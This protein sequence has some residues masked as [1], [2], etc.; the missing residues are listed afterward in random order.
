MLMAVS[1]WDPEGQTDFSTAVGTGPFTVKEFT[2]GVRSIGVRNENYW[3]DGPYLD[4]IE[5]FGIGDPV[6]RVSAL[7]AGD[8]QMMTGIDPEAVARLE[9]TPGVSAVN[10]P[11]GQFADFAMMIDREPMNNPDLRLAIKNLFDR[12]AIVNRLYKG[13]G[14]V[15]N[16]QPIPPMDPYY[17]DDLEPR[18]LDIDK[19]KYHLKKADMV[20]ATIELHTSTTASSGAVEQA[21]MLQQQAAKAGLTIDVTRDPADGY[22]S[23]IWGQKSFYMSGWNMRP[24]CDIMLTLAFKSDAGY[25]EAKW[26]SE[27]FDEL[28]DLGRAELDTARRKEYYCEAQRLISDTGG[29]AIPC[30]FGYLDAM[31]DNIKGFQPVPLGPLAAGQWPKHVWIDS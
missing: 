27:R 31:A 21:L 29:V 26:G 28:L 13:W 22:W 15:G 30:F 2:P 20:G 3:G 11:A 1:G 19:A 16:D 6:A 8:I 24:T 25:N 9:Q 14:M 7:L 17:C 4:E 10:T 12:E 18:P 23:N 5:W